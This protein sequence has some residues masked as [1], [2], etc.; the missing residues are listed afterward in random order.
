MPPAEIDER[1]L[2][3]VVAHRGA[4]AALPENTLES[5]DAAVRADADVVELDVRLTADGVPVILHDLDV[6]VATNGEGLVHELSLAELKSLDASKGRGPR[7]QVPTLKEALEHLRGRVA[8][9][10][11]VKNLPGEPTFDSPREAIVEA[12]VAALDETRFVGPLIVSSFNWLSIER[13]RE[14]RPE[15]PTG[16]LTTASVDAMAALEYAKRSG[17]DWVLPHTAALD[18]AG[19]ALLEVAHQA[20][21]RVGTWVAD[22]PA[23]LERLFE[24]GVDA[25]ATNDPE[26]AVPIRDR[27]R[28]RKLTGRS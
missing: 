21:I 2:P 7:T 9:D 17:H 10:V 25:V 24:M 4:S 26:T 16:L 20:G 27:Y 6:S 23:T 5:F 22:D 14:M 28:R 11:E 19:A 13:A 18:S 1:N 8:V 3:A 15:I 12:V